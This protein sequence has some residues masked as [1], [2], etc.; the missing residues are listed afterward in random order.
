MPPTHDDAAPTL[1]FRS[2]GA[3]SQLLRSQG[4]LGLGRAY[5]LGELETDD[6]DAVVALMGRWEPPSLSVS[7]RLRRSSTGT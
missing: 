7:Q 2:P 4:Q 1:K 5:V 6:L 3:I